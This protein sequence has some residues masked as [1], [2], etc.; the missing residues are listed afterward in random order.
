MRLQELHI[1]NFRKIADLTVRFPPGLCVIVGENNSGKTAIVD[2]LRFMF[3]SA[4]DF[5]ALRSD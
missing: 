1:R 5:D 4:R 3:L 2:A